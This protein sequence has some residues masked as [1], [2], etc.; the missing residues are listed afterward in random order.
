MNSFIGWVG[1]KRLL[2]YKII[3]CFPNEKEYNRY[4]EVFGGGGW[5]LFAK[6]KH[7]CKEIFND[8]NGELINL[9]RCVKYHCSELKKELD[10]LFISREIFEDFKMQ[11][12]YCN[13]TDIQRAARYYY[14]LKLSFAS[15]AN[16]FT[17]KK[18]IRFNKGI[19]YLDKIQE[20]LKD[21]VIENRDFEAIIKQQDS[22]KTLF[23]LDPPYLGAEKEYKYEF[24]L[25][26]HNK[27][28]ELLK[29]IKGKFVLSYNDN[30]IIRKMY[31][32]YNILEVSRQNNM[33]KNKNIPYKEVIIKNF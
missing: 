22:E 4:V 26:D 29:D 7:A 1:G 30:D 9:Y 33:S 23:Y 14:L 31:K 16:I 10:N 11:L 12:G 18:E 5:V 25:K 19:E 17:P 24:S 21:V 13:L 20:R 27:L 28:L 32:D 2:R 6:D 8:I 3:E 15:K